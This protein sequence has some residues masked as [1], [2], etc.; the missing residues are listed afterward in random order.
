MMPRGRPKIP[1]GE[2]TVNVSVRIPKEVYDFYRKYPN[3]SEAM[4]LALELVA[5]RAKR[6]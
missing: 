5:A 2:R 1:E 4:R 6:T 3:M